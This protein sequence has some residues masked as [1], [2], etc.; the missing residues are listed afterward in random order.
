MEALT[1]V[2]DDDS[3]KFLERELWS[4]RQAYASSG[5]VAQAETLLRVAN[6]VFP[7]SEFGRDASF[8]STVGA[9][10]AIRPV[11]SARAFATVSRG[12]IAW[13]ALVVLSLIWMV[14]R[15]VR[16][17]RARLWDLAVWLTATAL[18]GPIA[19]LVHMVG[20]RPIR[21]S[22]FS[23]VGY[24]LAWVVA[25]IALLA[26]AGEP[27]PP[28]ILG[29]TVL[30]PVLVGLFMIRAPVLR[31]AGIGSYANGLRR[32]I[33]AEVITW[34]FGFAVFFPL[35]FFLDDR[36]LSTIPSPSSPFF[37]AMMSVLA[38]AGLAVL[39]VLH[40]VMRRMGFTVGPGSVMVA[41][42]SGETLRLPRLRDSWWLLLIALVI[43]VGSL[44][45]TVSTLG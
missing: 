29:S 1:A 26:V 23:V 7:G 9:M 39:F 22:V 20:G 41:G 3:R 27:N 2:E 37:G 25:V 31:R 19:P 38:L 24:S 4:F 45:F 10:P 8:T 43:L 15:L 14:L 33:L 32:G 18:L 28:L 16:T 30:L 42:E 44:A 5:Q 35:T 36:W 17:R 13:M 40:T 21:A 6:T 11:A 12:V 34:G